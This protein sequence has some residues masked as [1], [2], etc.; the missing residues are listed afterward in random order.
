M[1]ENLDKL[2]KLLAEMFQFDQ[3]DLD[4][5]IY[6]I[7]SAKRDEIIH[8]IDNNLLPQIKEA[9]QQYQGE[10]RVTIQTKLDEAIKQ[11]KNLGAD[12]ESM[13]LIKKL[14]ADLAYAP[15]IIALQNDVYSHLYNF[16]RRYYREGDFISLRRYK[17]GVYA[18]P[19]EGEEVKLYWANHDQYYVKTSE[20]FRNYTFKLPS[21]KKVTFKVTEAE[22]ERDNNKATNGIERRFILGQGDKGSGRQ[23][24]KETRGQGEIWDIENGEL[25][26]FFRY[27]PDPERRKQSQL[28][29]EA[30]GRLKALLSESPGLHVSFSDLFAPQPTEKNPN[31]TLLEKHLND[32]TAKNTFDY[33]IHKD[34]EGFLRRELD[35]YIKNEVMHLDD[36]ESESAPRVEQYLSKIKVIRKIAHKL[37]EFLAQ[38]ENFQ[39]KLWLKKKFVVETNYCLTLDRVP[40]ELYHEIAANDTQREEWVR[41][42]AIDEINGDLTTPRYSE[43]LTVD[44]LNANPYLVLD[45]RHF[46]DDFKQRLLASFYDIDEQCDG[47]LVH[48]ENFQALNLLMERYRG[49]VK[50]IYIDPPYNTGND[51]FTYKDRY[52]H[53]SWLAMLFDRLAIAQKWLISDGLL[54]QSVDDNEEPRARLIGELVFGPLNHVANVI[55]QKKYTR[56]NDAR[57]FSDNHDYIL[58]FAKNKEQAQIALLPRTEEQESA[59]SNPDN[60]PRG[61]WKATPLHAK[62]GN[63][64]EFIYTFKNGVTWSPPPGTFPRYSPET[65]ERLYENNELWFGPDGKTTP[66]RKSFLSKVKQGVVPVT[67][68]PYDEVGHN[69]EAINEL[70]ALFPEN[71]FSNPKPTRLIRQVA[72]LSEADIILDFFAGS[73]TTAH[74]VINLN[75]ED[76][77]SRKYILVEMGDYFDT[78]LVPRIKKVVYSKDWK[79]GKPVSHDGISHMFKYIRLESYEDAL[80][81]L[82]LKRSNAQQR[83]LDEHPAFRE[84]YMLRYMLD[85]ESRGSA[86]LLNLDRFEDPFSYT[87]NIAV[88]TVGETKTTVVDLVETFNYLIGLRVKTIAHISDV[89]V[90]TGTNPQGERVLVLW[91]NTKEM[92]NDSLDKWFLQQS[93]NTEDQN[94]DLIYVNG[95]NNLENLRKPDQTWKVR[96]IEEEFK[97][98]MFDVS[99]V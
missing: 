13:P 21:G 75:R 5:G 65:L 69:H 29:A 81:N 30:I 51:E 20:N 44:F 36:I 49:Q 59:Y 55:W 94:F 50:C 62:S 16:F 99:E 26:I 80:N 96:L 78:V 61:P 79:D 71:P 9:F 73:G 52:Q 43:P 24:D 11:A 82:E 45:T 2:K 31:R 83:L 32:Y 35:F 74:A 89:R 8:F 19:Y 12:P 70:K 28:N 58:V 27:V 7:M 14:R 47:L 95:D 42:F 86:S 6:R 54:W 67:I 3:A 87:L 1:S 64:A 23:R 76:G 66:A 15:D 37:I 25:V 97:R 33:F 40:E 68:W 98:R 17:E 56:A 22:T 85:T 92:D 53:S 18:I 77:G 41:L 57:W 90:V 34:L 91:R 93:Y 39:K 63:G 72:F 60:D 88:G 38:I 48:S 4:F 46:S 84:D 10:D